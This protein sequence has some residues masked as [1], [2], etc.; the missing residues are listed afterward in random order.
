M[1]K[2]LLYVATCANTDL[3]HQASST[4]ASTSRE[5]R[6][7]FDDMVQHPIQYELSRPEKLFEEI[8]D[9]Y[10]SFYMLEPID[11]KWGRSPAS[12][13]ARLKLPQVMQSLCKVYASCMIYAIV[14]A[15]VCMIYAIVYAIV[16]A[17]LMQLFR[18]GRRAFLQYRTASAGRSRAR[19]ELRE[20]L[21]LEIAV[22][23][24]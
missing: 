6:F 11:V 14:Y 23:S 8:V 9:T 5:Q 22:D 2:S 16:Y 15:I 7:E 24:E 21:K 20:H 10:K 19:I 4:R 1:V 3:P 17:K 13:V 12:G 18:A